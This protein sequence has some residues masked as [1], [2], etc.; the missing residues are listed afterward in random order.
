MKVLVVED[1]SQT[2]EYIRKGL[3]EL[4]HAVDVA[5]SGHEGLV[6]ASDRSHNVVILDRM[7]PDLEG[8]NVLK[9]LRALGVQTPVLMLTAMGS[10]EDRVLG[11]ESGAD[12]Y[13][14]KPFAFSELYARLINLS[15][16]AT[17]VVPVTEFRVGDLE[18]NLLSREVRRAGVKIELHPT[19]FRLLEFFMRHA[20]QVVTK[21]MLLEGVWN[22]HFD[23]K[24]NVVET[25]VSRLRAKV[26][27]GFAKELIRTV[28]GAGYK[29]ES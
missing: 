8:M 22:F 17:G 15:R 28:R 10:L 7:L 1:D 13:L 27:K 14:V 25:H 4:G 6:Q 12:D 2:A 3:L 20:G 23:P 5:S 18:M 24:T 9:S 29:I 11:L 26:D 19:E 21:T 16:R